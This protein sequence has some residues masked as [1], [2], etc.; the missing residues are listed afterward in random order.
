MKKL[1]A[2][3]ILTAAAAGCSGGEAPEAHRKAESHKAPHNG[4]LNAIEKCS[5]GHVEALLEGNKLTLYFVGGHDKTTTSLP[6]AAESME[7]S[8][9]LENGSEKILVLDAKPMKLAG[10]KIG[11]C[12]RFEVADDFLK[13]ITRFDASS[14]VE[15][16]GTLRTIT[17]HY[18]EGYHP[19]HKEHEHHEGS[20]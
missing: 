16:N 4:V 5:V 8:I 10:E 11:N 1:I 17:I 13:G 9:E 7:L 6:I 20:E 2:I 12:S 18:P 3:L 19:G 14:E 15:I